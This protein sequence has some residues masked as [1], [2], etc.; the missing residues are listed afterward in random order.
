M[1][2]II[3]LI[4]LN[5]LSNLEYCNS[6]DLPLY[7]LT[8][9]HINDLHARFDETN[10]KS[11]KCVPA[12]APCIAGFARVA[13]TIKKLLNDNK[14][15]I[16]LNAGDNYQGTL[17]YSL[18]KW[19]VTL[20]LM[21][22]LVPAA[23]ALGNH[24]FDDAISGLIPYIKGLKSPTVCANILTEDEPELH[25]LNKIKPY[26]VIE[27]SGRKIGI[28]GV[29]FDKIHDISSTEKVRFTSSIDAVKK[30]SEMLK[31]QG[32][33][34]VIVLSHCGLDLDKEIADK[35]G[36]NID[37]IIG[38]HSHAFL[39]TGSNPPSKDQI[40]G[41]YPIVVEHGRGH[42]VLITQ[43]LAYGKYVGNIKV[44]FDQK[45]EVQKWEGQPIYQ[46]SKIRVDAGISKAMKP[47][48]QEVKRLGSTQIG[49]TEISLNREHCRKQ[50]CTLGSLVADAFQNEY[51]TET[52]TPLAIIQAGYFRNPIEA[53][54]ITYGDALESIPYGS[55]VDLIEISGNDLRE[56]LENSVKKDHEGR[57]NVAQV[58]G[59]TVEYDM[60]KPEGSRVIQCQVM[61]EENGNYVSRPLRNNKSYKVVAPSFIIGGG[62]KFTSLTNGKSRHVGR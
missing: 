18:L 39:Y 35:A 62:D 43:A 57:L 17:W 34:I 20:D 23:M 61:S 37:I 47:W 50:E 29:S 14:N 44:F 36:E 5:L 15:S 52:L 4:L 21:N 13:T 22:R 32:V 19:N 28:I 6:V 41:D 10:E 40:E 12:R 3:A 45:G 8:I 55:S 46:S 11:G 38:G 9:A 24:E 58:A 2:L 33:N 53:G 56:A 7:E 54:D 60:S 30:Y 26:I 1:P 49:K 51:Q 59:I 16:Y 31:N 25:K 48:R 42:K 27:K